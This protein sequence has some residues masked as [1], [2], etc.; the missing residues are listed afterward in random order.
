MLWKIPQR[1]KSQHFLGH[2]IIKKR[3]IEFGVILSIGKWQ[4]DLHIWR[5]TRNL[6]KSDNKYVLLI[7]S[8]FCTMGVFQKQL[9]SLRNSNRSSVSNNGDSQ[10]CLSQ[11]N[12]VYAQT[13][14]LNSDA[15][16]PLSSNCDVPVSVSNQTVNC[17]AGSNAHESVEV[18]NNH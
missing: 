12:T 7:F 10:Q 5:K 8:V 2:R 17:A 16:Q 11:T 6:N 4:C 18:P 3:F 13:A 9:G 15:R 14:R 1:K